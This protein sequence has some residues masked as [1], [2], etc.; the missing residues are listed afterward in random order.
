MQDFCKK[1][2]AEEIAAAKAKQEAEF[3]QTK[4]I[5]PKAGVPSEF[6]FSHGPVSNQSY[7]A[8]ISRLHY[9]DPPSRG[10]PANT[11]LPTAA[12]AAAAAAGSVGRGGAAAAAAMDSSDPDGDRCVG[13]CMLS[14][15]TAPSRAHACTSL[16]S[17]ARST[18]INTC[19]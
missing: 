6:I 11:A 18:L 5:E 15:G 10:A 14:Q 4:R 17:M 3:S 7:Q 19:P 13:T 9:T 12:A 8:S 2:E 1:Q 16:S